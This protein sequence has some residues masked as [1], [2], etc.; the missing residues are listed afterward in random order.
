M[1]KI[2]QGKWMW[3]AAIALSLGIVGCN[4]FHPTDS[5]DADNDDAAAL[6]LEGYLEFQKANYDEARKFFNKAVRADSAYSEAWIGLAKAVLNTQKGLNVFELVSYSQKTV[7][8]DGTSTNKLLQMSD[9]EAQVIARGIDT[10]MTILNK[11]VARDTTGKTDK[12][13]RFNNIADS[14]TI[15]QLT[16]AALRI[17]DIK[18]QLTSVISADNAGMMMNLNVL[19][20]IGDSLKPFLNDLASAAEAIKAAPESASEIIKAYLPDSTLTDFTGEDYADLTVGL[21]NSIIQLNDRAQ[22]TDDDRTDVFFKFG[23]IIDDDG[24]GCVDEEILDNYDNDGDGEIDED[25]RDNRVIVLVKKP[26]NI[27]ETIV[28]VKDP[29]TY[30]LTKAQVDS[31]N[32]IEKYYYVDIDMNGKQALNDPEEWHFVYRKPNKRDSLQNHRFLFTNYIG[33][34]DSSAIS[35]FKFPEV[36]GTNDSLKLVELI[37]RKELIRK[38][39]D[40]NNRKYTLEARQEMV[41]GCWNNYKTEEDFLKWFQWR[42]AK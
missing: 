26:T 17:R 1:R 14:Y 31:L 24:D 19:N 21:A 6:T 40:K 4:L 35:K 13:I 23:N 20:D 9:E 36:L 10:V 32:L 29:T 30:D 22:N 7:A 15:L 8:E 27:N 3:S 37:K 28:L 38:D 16:K 33:F 41:G 2:S 42:D 25:V 5:R 39:T 34:G 18:T 11:F 12:K